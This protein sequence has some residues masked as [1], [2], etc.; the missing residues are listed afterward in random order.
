MVLTSRLIYKLLKF[1]EHF[2][3]E[4]VFIK[5]FI[6]N[7]PVRYP[8]LGYIDLLGSCQ[9][10]EF[11]YSVARNCAHSNLDVNALLELFGD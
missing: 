9:V 11:V 3:G 1:K 5:Y 6:S 4:K 2:G 10:E 8:R 7:E